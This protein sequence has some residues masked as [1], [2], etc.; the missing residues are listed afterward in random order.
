MAIQYSGG[1]LV[2]NTFTANSLATFCSGVQT[3]L[4]TAGWSVVS[5]GGTTDVKFQSATTPQGLAFRMRMYAGAAGAKFQLNNPAE[6][7]ATGDFGYFNYGTNL[8]VRIVANQ[9]QAFI[10]HPS[11]WNDFVAF[12]TPWIPA[13]LEGVITEAFWGQSTRVSDNGASMACSFRNRLSAAGAG[14]GAASQCASINGSVWCYTNNFDGNGGYTGYQQL[15]TIVA[16]HNVGV[17]GMWHSG[18]VVVAEPLISWGAIGRGD[19]ALIRGQLWDGL[20]YTNNIMAEQIFT[21]DSHD[22]LV[23]TGANAYDTTGSLCIAVT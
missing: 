13:F 17:A 19:P 12:G 10:M 6:T 7:S 18:D 11:Y 3:A 16:A 21:F 15:W 1:T 2:N 8:T 5:G 23:I 20:I 14:T 9:Y 22:W 4:T